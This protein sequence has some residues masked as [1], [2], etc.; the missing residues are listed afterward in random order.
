MITD[1]SYIQNGEYGGENG[2]PFKAV[3]DPLGIIYAKYDAS[4]S[5]IEPVGAMS[6]DVDSQDA[7][8]SG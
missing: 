1:I 8:G 4:V 6:K 5:N 7:G 3:F 2:I